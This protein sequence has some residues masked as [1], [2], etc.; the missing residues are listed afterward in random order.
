MTYNMTDTTLKIG[1]L[2]L[3]MTQFEVP[4]KLLFYL[5]KLIIGITRL[6]ARKLKLKKLRKSLVLPLMPIK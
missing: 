2:D 6:M 4:K 5:L 1:Q 3:D